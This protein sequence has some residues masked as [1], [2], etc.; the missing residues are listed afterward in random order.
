MRAP[1]Q[2][3]E[4]PFPVKYGYC[5]VGRVES[6][7]RE[8]VGRDVF[9]LHPHQDV[10][11]V[12]PAWLV[13]LPDGVP[14]RRAVL[15]A[16]ME[17]A[18]NALWDSG[19]GPGDRV[20]IVGGGVVGLLVAYL[21]A[22]LPA[23]E[24]IVSDIA[25][26]RAA[27]AKA[28]GAGYALP[29]ALGDD[30]DIVFHTSAT[31]AGL[32]TAIGACANEATIVEMSWY[33]DGTV[34]VPLGGAFHSRRLRIVSSQVGQ[35]AP[36]H[37]SRWTHRRRLAKALELLADERLDE[38]ITNEVAFADLPNALPSLLA[39]GAPGLVTAVRY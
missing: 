14:P 13:P 21:C 9:A 33:G 12:D 39:A 29:Q 2:D 16:N 38:L 22:C 23:A 10:F 30:A 6:G 31:A 5:A 35:V 1:L 24:V 34:A 8:L 15:A 36:S 19:A 25:P 20:V 7:P 27:I 32:A 3:G 4:F 28:L 26:E 11:T 37:R 18:L 17:T